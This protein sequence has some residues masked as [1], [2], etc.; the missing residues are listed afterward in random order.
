MEQTVHTYCRICLANCGLDVT[1]ADGRVTEIAPDRE[2]P[3]TW[4]DFC[5]KGKTANE[6]VEHPQRIT[7]PM[8]RVGDTYV[9]STYA[10]AIAD[11]AKRLNAIIER[12]GADAVGSYHGNPMGFS[13]AT[14]SF[15]TGLLDAIGTGNRFWVGS[16]DQNNAHVVAEELYGSEL[17]ALVPDIDDC[18]CFLLVGMDPVHSRFNWLENNPNGWQRVL[19]RRRQG[20]DLIVVDPRRSDTARKADTHVPVL[21]GQDWAFLLG[22]IKVVLERGWARPSTVVPLTGVEELRQLAAA[23][24]LDELAARAGVERATIEDVAQRFATARTAMCVAHTGVAHNEHGTIGEWLA[25]ALNLLTDRVDRPGGRRFER[26]YVDM[27]MILKLF[28]PAADHKTRLRGTPPIVGFHSLAE[29]PD[30]I[31]TPGTGQIKALLLAFGNPVVSGPDGAALDAAMEELDLLVAI[32]L[33]QRESHRHAHWLLPGTHWLEREEL[34]PLLGGLQDRPYVHYA[35]KAVDP[36]AGVLEEW[37]LFTELALAMDRNLFGKPG[38]N[39]VVKASRALARRT[40]RPGLA[41]NPGWIQRLLVL[42]GRRL[43]WKDI[44][45][46][47]HGWLYA[48]KRFGDLP[49]VVGHEDKKVR[50][51]PEAFLAATRAALSSVPPTSAERPLLL[52]NKRRREAM[53]SW[54]N[55]SPG[56]FRNGRDTVAEVHPDD[57][58]AAGVAD[59]DRVRLVSA[60]GAIELEVSVTDAMRPG[61]VCV[62]HGWGGRT[63]DPAGERPPEALGANR[64]LLVDNV[65]LDALSQTPA[66]N[67]TSVRLERVAR[68]AKPEPAATAAA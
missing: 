56:L 10:E 66:F 42:L 25:Q 45:S 57:A 14:T 40:G 65:R 2:N 62:P 8:K 58:A 17:V 53:N 12:D 32:D 51:A 33:V 63:Y 11:I 6:V 35:Q 21:P 23:A 39:R 20:A 13:F 22:V 34:S 54:L 68:G 16:I 46:K 27:P 1:V 9:E 37:E 3:Y 19:D 61:V 26:G 59:G 60:T 47:P 7:R 28:A 50:L 5:K 48:E 49:G 41:M 43:K 44:R 24:S 4:R 55:E 18:D 30:E 31:T 29:L 52:I 38:V 64:N 67:S 36:P 15:W